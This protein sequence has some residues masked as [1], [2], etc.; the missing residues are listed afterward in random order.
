VGIND[1]EF[2]LGVLIIVFVEVD[3]EDAIVGLG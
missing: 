3:D 2:R 1:P